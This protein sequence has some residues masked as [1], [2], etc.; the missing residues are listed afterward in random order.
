[1]V[2]NARA[3]RDESGAPASCS[4]LAF[5]A[6]PVVASRPNKTTHARLI[7]YVHLNEFFAA[8]ANP[9]LEKRYRTVVNV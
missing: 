2:S 3:A 7:P 1:M 5:I 8:A 4:T 6:A 9:T